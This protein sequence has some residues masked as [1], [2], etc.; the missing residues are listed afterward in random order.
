MR[1]KYFIYLLLFAV[2]FCMLHPVS[3]KSVDSII[4]DTAFAENA[5]ALA[6]LADS[7][8][9]AGQLDT[10]Q[11]LAYQ[12]VAIARKNLDENDTTLAYT[13]NVLGKCRYFAS[14]YISSESLWIESL[15]IR[16][17]A[18]GGKSLKVA[19][20]LNNLGALAKTLGKYAQAESLYAKMLSIREEI[21]GPNHA[22]VAL[23]LN[24]L[25]SLYRVE[26]R[27]AEAE[28][29][30]KR[31]L[32]INE[33]TLGPDHFN[34]AGCLNNLGVLHDE[35][36]RYDEAEPLYQRALA[37]REK[38]FGSDNPQVAAS[39]NN[40]ASLYY[41]QG[42]YDKAESLFVRSLKIRGQ[43][44]GPGQLALA[45]TMNNLASL[46]M[47]IGQYAKAET[48]F[49]KALDIK[50]KTLGPDN[51]LL[52]SSYD[53]LATLYYNQGKYTESEAYHLKA[54]VIYEQAYGSGH[55]YVASC[56]ENLAKLHASTRNFDASLKDFISAQKS[57]IDFIDDVFVYA[58]EGQK[59]NYIDKYP[60]IN[61]RFLS[62]AARINSDES[63]RAALEM[64]LKGKA[65]VVDAVTAEKEIAY[66]S[67]E[68]ET[69]VKLS[70]LARICGEISTLTL[71]GAETLEPAIYQQRLELLYHVKDSLE[72]ELSSDC[73]EF[74][75]ELSLRRFKLDDVAKVLPN[76][77]IL[78]EIV[79]YEP[80]D[81]EKIGSDRKK[82]SNS[83]YLAL[84]FNKQKD[85][86][87]IDLGEAALIDSLIR[88][89]RKMIY[90]AG[91]GIY[92]LGE[93]KAEEEL[94]KVTG[95]LYDLVF[96]PMLSLSESASEI[97][98]SPD[99]L[100]NLLPFDILPC[101]GGKYVVEQYK[102]SYLSSGRDLLRFN[103]EPEANNLVILMA[104]PNF[105]LDR[106][107][108]DSENSRNQTEINGVEINPFEPSRG[109]AD[110]FSNR[111]DP[112]PFACEE[113]GFIA[114]TFEDN[115]GFEVK[116]F[117]GDDALEENL[118]CMVAAPRVLHLAT[119]GFFCEDISLIQRKFIENPLL[120]SGIVLAGANRLID[121][122]NNIDLTKEDGILTA[123][124]VSG[125]N[126][127]GTVL[128]TLSA[129]ETGVGEIKNGE[130]VFGLRRAF[131]HAG[132]ET[133]LMSLWKIQEKQTSELM[134]GFY[135][136]W[137]AGSTKRDALRQAILSIIEKGRDQH[138]AAHPFYWGAFVLVGNPY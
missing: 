137:L 115:D 57:R 12:A 14:D 16:E 111:F 86:S 88:Q 48:L 36:G 135:S 28:P 77:G 24:N 62:L 32:R 20:S 84:T 113:A 76:N 42:K 124:E 73:A 92:A 15:S 44:R 49:I 51:S 107:R 96:R 133:I 33:E 65:S 117:Y 1:S 126:L 45:S 64:I 130:G 103:N 58:S 109:S 41:N 116:M 39:L 119:H 82:T 23:G 83:C 81:Y 102:L 54:L 132:A 80:Y 59:I 10:A 52:A 79:A 69:K 93:S 5:N 31:A 94:N 4:P 127:S 19:G 129:C 67:A 63:K 47:D 136:I 34:V 6:K 90:D 89:T 108:A 2:C 118:K 78:W 25:G 123:F 38:S 56:R 71:S 87:I 104:G 72:T 112:L 60:L 29:L 61:D 101:P 110:C 106:T 66:H 131:Q 75:T 125:L 53:N 50:L 128:V 27:Y 30:F 91:A 13:L 26:G 85:I 95:R 121:N 7:L 68:K 55:P 22:E 43:A 8:A 134:E 98:I 138:Q 105:D 70:E 11:S 21:Q 120:R 46:F 114:K 100:L 99:G 9:Q 40:L 37:I 74:R 18:L 122:S 97:F 17:K 35:Q 3:T